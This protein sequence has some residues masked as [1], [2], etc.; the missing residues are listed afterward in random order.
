MTV[1]VDASAL[2]AWLRN[3]PG[4]EVVE[5]VFDV[6]VMSAA[7]AAEVAERLH[8]SPGLRRDQN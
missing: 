8:I 4:G 2:L 6:A 1:V 3:E 7:N 5:S